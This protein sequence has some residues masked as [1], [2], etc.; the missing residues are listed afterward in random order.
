[1]AAKSCAAEAIPTYHGVTAAQF[2]D[3]IQSKRSPAVLR[4]LDLGPCVENWSSLPYLLDHIEDKP[5]KV[6]K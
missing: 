2:R 4:G 1:M 6:T 3:S 5:V